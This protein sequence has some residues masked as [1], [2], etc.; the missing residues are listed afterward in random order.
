MVAHY[1][2][3]LDYFPCADYATYQQ[4]ELGQVTNLS[5]PFFFICKM[6]SF[7]L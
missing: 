6:S 5:E 2:T 7:L 3:L 4:F 1:L